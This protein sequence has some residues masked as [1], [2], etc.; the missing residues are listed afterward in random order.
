MAIGVPY[1]HAMPMSQH[2]INCPDC[3]G[4]LPFFAKLP[5][6]PEIGQLQVYLMTEL[7]PHT[8]LC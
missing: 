1:G 4:L 8:P 5:K 6:A 2:C 3:L 7:T